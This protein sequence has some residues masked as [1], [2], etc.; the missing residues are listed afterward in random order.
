MSATVNNFDYLDN[1]HIHSA[2]NPTQL[3][4]PDSADSGGMEAFAGALFLVK[5][6][7]IKVNE[8]ILTTLMDDKFIHFGRNQ[9]SPLLFFFILFADLPCCK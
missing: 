4:S 3:Q 9:L 8:M 1:L 7:P 2:V 6:I 5:T